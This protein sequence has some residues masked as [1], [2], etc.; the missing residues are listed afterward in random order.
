MLPGCDPAF[1]RL[2]C[3]PQHELP[4]HDMFVDLFGSQ[5]FSYQEFIDCIADPVAGVIGICNLPCV[6]DSQCRLA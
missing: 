4:A 1:Q 3:L 2:W 6:P 5:P